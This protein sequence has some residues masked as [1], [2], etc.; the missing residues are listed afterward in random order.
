MPERGAAGSIACAGALGASRDPHDG[1]GGHRREKP[2]VPPALSPPPRGRPRRPRADRRGRGWPPCPVPQRPTPRYGPDPQARWHRGPR[3]ADRRRNRSELG[4]HDRSREPD[5]RR[6]VSGPGTGAGRVRP[7]APASSPLLRNRA[8]AG[9]VRGSAILQVRHHPPPAWTSRL[10]DSYLADEPRSAVGAL[11]RKDRGGMRSSPRLAS[12]LAQTLAL[13]ASLLRAVS[14]QS[15]D[16][17]H[18]IEIGATGGGG[19]IL[20]PRTE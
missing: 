5:R 17:S 19:V 9:R 8:S 11:E 6:R 2:G 3:A 12:L 15:P 14:A 20:V 7:S 4:P 18:R 10:V 13:P 16:V 1:E